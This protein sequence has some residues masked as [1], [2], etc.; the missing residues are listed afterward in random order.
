MTEITTKIKAAE[1]IA[2]VV[3]HP[4]A[5]EIIPSPLNPHVMSAVAGVF[6]QN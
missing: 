1:A 6:K 4:T 3:N 5:N 2:S